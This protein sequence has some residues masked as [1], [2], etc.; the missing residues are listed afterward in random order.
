[1]KDQEKLFL[2]L[3][4]QNKIKWNFD[5]LEM[6]KYLRKKGFTEYQN[7]HWAGWWQITNKGKIFAGI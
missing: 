5:N 7:S 6:V 1:M 3:L 4:C 2:K